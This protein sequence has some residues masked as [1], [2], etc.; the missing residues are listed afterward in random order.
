MRLA[1]SC[2]AARMTAAAVAAHVAAAFVRVEEEVHA[3]RAELAAHVLH[4]RRRQARGRR[5]RRTSCPARAGTPPGCTSPGSGRRSSVSTIDALASCSA[6]SRPARTRCGSAAAGPDGGHGGAAPGPARGEPRARRRAR[7]GRRPQPWARAPVMRA[8]SAAARAARRQTGGTPPPARTARSTERARA[9]L[10]LPAAP[11]SIGAR[12]HPAGMPRARA[13]PRARAAQARRA[14]TGESRAAAEVSSRRPRPRRRRAVARTRR[15]GARHGRAQRGDARAD[16][17]TQRVPREGGHGVALLDPRG[18]R[19][20]AGP[21]GTGAP[22]AGTAF[23]PPRCAAAR[24]RSA[25]ARRAT[26]WRSCERRVTAA[27]RVRGRGAARASLMPG[28]PASRT[29]VDP[30]AALSV[31]ERHELRVRPVHATSR[32][33]PPLGEASPGGSLA[34]PHGSHLRRELVAAVA[35]SG[36]AA[37]AQA[38]DPSL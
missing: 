4:R 8:G 13:S 28:H 36:R 22:P 21:G 20:A 38:V 1:A 6:I 2:R 19:R 5:P 18:R 37:P 31:I 16:E 9:F 12:Q 27:S 29:S 32:E 17:R 35:G 15:R 30:R 23:F 7:S 24:A 14:P 26:D 11:P 34:T 25:A 10:R 3:Q 33:R